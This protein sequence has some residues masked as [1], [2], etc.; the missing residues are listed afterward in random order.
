VADQHPAPV[1]AGVDG[2]TDSRTAAGLAAWEAIRRN[3]SLRLVYGFD[4]PL[5]AGQVMLPPEV[6]RAPLEAAGTVLTETAG[7]I[8]RDHPGL[9]IDTAVTVGHPTNVLVDESRAAALVVLGSRGLGG[10]A[11]LLVGSVSAQVAAH[12]RAP[13][14][15][16]RAGRGGPRSTPVPDPGPVVV[17]V[18]GSGRSA[19]AVEF[20]FDEA[21]GRDQPLLA[22]YAWDVP[23]PGSAAA[24]RVPEEATAGVSQRYP[25]VAVRHRTT[26]TTNPAKALLEVGDEVDAG[27]LVVGSRGRGG[28]TG[29]LLGSVSQAL[30]GHARR[31]VGI[32]H[33]PA[34]A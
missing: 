22:V 28:F 31:T 13:V 12:A 14:L 30:L 32:V 7:A 4:Q 17:G 15:V 21:A 9:H 33:P 1:V 11:G 19:A 34:Q 20:A 2:S 10:F 8:R 27:L 24:H 23:R 25:T 16:V 5:T 18:D 26:D 6:V 29:L 3:R